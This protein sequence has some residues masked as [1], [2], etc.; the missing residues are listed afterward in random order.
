ML[1]T[2]GEASRS[3]GIEA[4]AESIE[5]S[6]KSAE[7]ETISGELIKTDF[8]ILFLAIC[9]GFLSRL[10]DCLHTLLLIYLKALSLG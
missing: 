3:G 5:D 10:T 7:E 6:R 1:P 8:P 2:A 4:R 9:L